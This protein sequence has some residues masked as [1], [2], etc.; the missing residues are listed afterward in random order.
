MARQVRWDM[1]GKVRCGMGGKV[2]SG[3]VRYG[4]VRQVWK[5]GGNFNGLRMEIQYA[6]KGAD[7]RRTL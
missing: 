7:C 1:E 2:R 5:K 3:E 4:K 6:D